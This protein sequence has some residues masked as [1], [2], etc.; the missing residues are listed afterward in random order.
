MP[1]LGQ[2]HSGGD[3]D[4]D[5]KCGLPRR[6]SPD[7]WPLNVVCGRTAR[8]VCWLPDPWRERKKGLRRV[9]VVGSSVGVKYEGVLS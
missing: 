4:E 9:L 2:P 1:K 5:W 8:G 6:Q 3:G 7:N